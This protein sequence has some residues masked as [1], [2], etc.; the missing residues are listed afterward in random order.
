MKRLL[1]YLLCTLSVLC[2]VLLSALMF[3]IQV[4]PARAASTLP[5]SYFSPYVDV[6]LT[7]T[8]NMTQTE[9]ETGQKYY[10]LAFVLD[11]GGCNAEWAG[12]TPINQGFM[13]SDI[14]SLRAAGGDVIAS[15][16]GEVGTELATSCGSESAL[17][18]QYQAV[19][20]DYNLTH[21]DFDIEGSTLDN[22]TANALRDQAIVGLEKAA[23]SAGKQLTVSFTIPVTANGLL[24]DGLAL[25]QG[26]VA[27]GVNFTVVNIMT[28]DLGGSTDGDTGT[29]AIDAALGL[30]KQL[31]ALFPTKSSSQLWAMI[32]MTPM[33][34]LNGS[35]GE[36]FTEADAQTVL[37]F[38]QQ[39]SLGE[40]AMW[41]AGRDAECPGDASTISTTCSGITQ[42]PFDFTKIFA[43][44]NTSNSVPPTPTPTPPSGNLVSNP[45]FETGTTVGWFCDPNDAVVSNPVHSGSHAVEVVSG[46]VTVGLCV[47]TI[48]VQPTTAYTLTAYLQG[49]YIYLGASGYT[50]TWTSSSSYTQLTVTFTTTASTS[51]VTIYTQGYFGEGNGFA[52]DFVLSG[53]GGSAT[54]TP[55]ATPMPTATPTHTATATPTPTATPTHTPT[56]TPTTPTP[57]PTAT[58][59]NLVSNPGFETGNLTSW[60]CASG[61]TVV[62]S[63]VH[64]GSYALAIAPTSSST[65]E[66]DQTILVQANHTYTLTAYVDGSYA[67]L[68]VQN[69][70]STWTSSSSYTKLSVTFTTS[71]SQTSITIYVHGWYAQ[72]NVYVDD[73]SLS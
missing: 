73:V 33:I 52:D 49:G 20:N 18:A 1:R 31:A 72:G 44:F 61:D 24:S 34:G 55:T 29:L 9:Q 71:A 6:S 66:C 63:P 27:A 16:G 14:S 17:Q 69:G 47:Q 21:I 38:A 3:W 37:A 45:G 13:Q 2:L 46:T 48:S 32:G 39:H 11:G 22:T 35:G 40:L 60:S 54:P 12:T 7:P 4:R 15:F 62:T 65:G 67:Y 28:M 26:A 36:V 41:S 5:T 25:L 64:S 58:S 59:G 42:N 43:A 30:Y 51:F 53:P 68:G 10:T 23:Q 70:T 50:S 8:F 56:S 57:T 19:I